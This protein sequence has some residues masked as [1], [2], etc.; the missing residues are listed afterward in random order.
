L[1]FLRY[2]ARGFGSH[3]KIAILPLAHCYHMLAYHEVV[4]QPHQRCCRAVRCASTIPHRPTMG[5]S[6]RGIV[7]GT[8][9]VGNSPE[10]H[11]RA[12]QT[13]S[14][15]SNQGPY[16]YCWCPHRTELFMLCRQRH[17]LSSLRWK[18]PRGSHNIWIFR[19]LRL[20][21]T[22]LDRRGAHIVDIA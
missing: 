4:A 3:V 19:D 2:L 1:K 16:S 13:M 18:A 17:V 7:L 8:I 15:D 21:S 6:P 22:Y 12:I 11:A 14:N 10:A 5:S 20:A 9:A